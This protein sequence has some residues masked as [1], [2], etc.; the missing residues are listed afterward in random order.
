MRDNKSLRWKVLYGVAGLIDIVQALCTPTG[1]GLIINELLEVVTPFILLALLWFFRM[2]STFSLFSIA[3]ADGLDVLSGGAAPCWAGDVALIHIRT[4]IKEKAEENSA[5][6][7]AFLKSG[8]KPPLNV[9]DRRLPPPVPGPQNS[10]SIQR[11]IDGI[12]RPGGDW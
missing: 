5:A 11:N 3:G 7:S 2:I 1:F 8:T 6:L 4:N 12:R 10:A 9:G